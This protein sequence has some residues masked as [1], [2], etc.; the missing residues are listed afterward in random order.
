LGSI[1]EI[2]TLLFVAL[3]I[4]GC[5][6]NVSGGYALGVP[7]SMAWHS[8]T[9]YSERISYFNSLSTVRLCSKWK[10]TSYDENKELIGQALSN[11]GKDEFFC[12]K[13]PN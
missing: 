13:L 6:Q 12:A 8:T 11:R 1:N 10:S 9:S 3:L 2:F 4:Q 5:S 7:G